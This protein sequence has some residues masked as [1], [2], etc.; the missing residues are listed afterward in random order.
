M[1]EESLRGEAVSM[2]HTFLLDE[3]LPTYSVAQT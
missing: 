2:K 3:C 1:R